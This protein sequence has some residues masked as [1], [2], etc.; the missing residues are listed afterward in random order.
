MN[1]KIWVGVAIVTVVI[2]L[3]SAVFFLVKKKSSI[4]Q[5]E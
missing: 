2:A 3:A 5:S 4:E 1:K